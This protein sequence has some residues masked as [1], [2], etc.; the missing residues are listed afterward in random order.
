M[1]NKQENCH[2]GGNGGGVTLDR[3]RLRDVPTA[4]L[5]LADTDHALKV[6]E[7]FGVAFGEEPD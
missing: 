2:L 6:W 1:A 5:Y 4:V 3:L 7:V